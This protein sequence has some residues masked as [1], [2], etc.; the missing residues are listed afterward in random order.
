MSAKLQ[1]QTEKKTALGGKKKYL[2]A[3]AV[4]T[5]IVI[6][7]ASVTAIVQSN[8]RKVSTVSATK[9]EQLS[10]DDIPVKIGLVKDNTYENEYFHIAF[11]LPQQYRFKTKE[12]MF[13]GIYSGGQYIYQDR[14]AVECYGGYNDA[15]VISTNGEGGG[16]MLTYV[17]EKNNKEAEFTDCESYLKGVD[18]EFLVY[19]TEAK[20]IS[21]IYDVKIANCPF[22]AMKIECDWGDDYFF[23]T[24][25]N[26]KYFLIRVF[27]DNND[28]KAMKVFLNMFYAL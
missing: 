27:V 7:L 11:T 1:V 21:D 4:I 17:Y 24:E 10:D 22:K 18:N 6:A 26:G 15:D 25:N 16:A 13:D 20:S 19:K 3:A 5:A 23:V 8:K 9:A 12:E 2:I 14:Y 28:E